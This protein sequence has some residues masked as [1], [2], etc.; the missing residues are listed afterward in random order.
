V[1]SE[2]ILYAYNTAE[3]FKPGHQ[4]SATKL[5][6][7]YATNELA[8]KVSSADVII[9]SICPGMVKT[10]IGREVQF[11]G[12]KVALA[13]IAFLVMRSPE[14]GARSILS[15]TTQG[16]SLHGRFWQHDRIQPVGKNI[17]GDE[18]KKLG[19]R[20]WNEIIEALSRDVPNV[21]EVLQSVVGEG[22]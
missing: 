16:E 10:D 12:V 11:P 18:K 9:T 14:Q 7:I 8:E 17:A 2:S 5:F 6:L 4:Y 19:V 1:Q 13:I 22:R 3:I 15:G 21:R 20:V